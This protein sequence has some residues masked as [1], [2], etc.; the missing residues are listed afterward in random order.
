MELK[1]ARNIAIVLAIAAAVY[2]VPGGGRAA[3]TF[4]AVL[5][6]GFAVAFGYLGLRLYRERR[7]AIYSLGDRHRG[8]LYGAAAAVVFLA[9]SATRLF[10]TGVGEL[11]WFVLLAG[12]FYA[13]MEIYRH[14][15]SY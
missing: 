14:V 8:L 2:F 7:V 6:V 3:S 15:R 10:E 1:T 5:I 9:V 4:E 12:V 13:A 11:V